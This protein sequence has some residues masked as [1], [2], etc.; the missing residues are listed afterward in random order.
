MKYIFIG[1]I[2]TLSWLFLPELTPVH[3]AEVRVVEIHPSFSGDRFSTIHPIT[4]GGNI[5]NYRGKKAVF[6]SSPTSI[7]PIKGKGFMLIRT[8]HSYILFEGADGNPTSTLTSGGPYDRNGCEPFNV[9]WPEQDFIK[10]NGVH[11]YG[12]TWGLHIEYYNPCTLTEAIPALYLHIYDE[13]DWYALPQPPGTNLTL[14]H[15]EG[16]LDNAPPLGNWA[17]NIARVVE[18][19]IAYHGGALVFTGTPDGTKPF[20]TKHGIYGL[21]LIDTNGGYLFNKELPLNPA[22]IKDPKG[23]LII[24]LEDKTPR[25][26]KVQVIYDIR[27]SGYLGKTITYPL[28]ILEKDIPGVLSTDTVAPFLDLPWKYWDETSDEL[29]KPEELEN[30]KNKFQTVAAKI[31]SYFDHKYPLCYSPFKHLDDAQCNSTSKT[32]LTYRNIL[33][34]YY[35]GH[36][37]YDWNT[38]VFKARERILAK[39]NGTATYYPPS[40]NAAKGHHLVV[41]YQNGQ[42]EEYTLLVNPSDEP[43]TVT[44]TNVPIV[45]GQLL[46]RQSEPILAAADGI[47]TTGY[48]NGWGRYIKI[49][50]GNGFQTIY[51]HLQNDSFVTGQVKAGERIGVAG[52]TGNVRSSN[53]ETQGVHLHFGVL[54]DKNNNGFALPDDYVDPFGWQPDDKNAKDP[55]E[56]LVLTK[57]ADGSALRTGSK[58]YYLWKFSNALPETPPAKTPPPLAAGNF[59]VVFTKPSG[60]FS[61]SPLSI[62]AVLSPILGFIE[63]IGNLIPVS[64]LLKLEAKNESGASVSQFQNDV[65]I[66]Y[67]LDTSHL[68]QNNS[69]KLYTSKD[70]TTWNLEPTTVTYNNNMLSACVKHFTYFVFMGEPQDGSPPTTQAYLK[71]NSGV[72]NVYRSDVELSLTAEDGNGGS[73]VAAT[74][75]S[76]NGASRHIYT[77]PLVFTQEGTHEVLFYSEDEAHNIEIPKKVSF[78]IDK[79]PPE[80]V[81]TFNK[82]VDALEILPKTD[83]IA[84]P[85]SE[86]TPGYVRITSTLSSIKNRKHWVEHTLTDAAG[87][88][89]TLLTKDKNELRKDSITIDEL[90]YNSTP[91]ALFTKIWLSVNG[92]LKKNSTEEARFQQV[93]RLH[94]GTG[95]KEKV[96]LLWRSKT[97][98]TTIKELAGT[99]E[100]KISTKSG[101]L[102][103]QLSFDNGTVKY[104]W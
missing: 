5:P 32:T 43:K 54:H 22:V 92:S 84:T 1:L 56:E 33:A 31:G 93:Y 12:E 81:I 53:P 26:L 46:A 25:S 60:E 76:V 24:E 78:T 85:G 98:S 91:S 96:S 8:A 61:E 30:R 68:Y 52:H 104:A 102:L 55:W 36:D 35:S 69:Y 10:T 64:P 62:K 71:G 6:S 2:F 70:G 16:N 65:C 59:Q 74:Y 94:T 29:N 34:N 3:A 13:E 14:I 28:Y 80:F 79:T 37:G 63:K 17:P 27:N 86:L 90:Y 20:F 4:T 19:E 48:D 75:V 97:G 50:H 41:T 7:E 66:S 82:L 99:Q 15:S 39:D 101:Q 44:D 87:N 89:T 45:K 18:K 21:N 72:S 49:D 23:P 42:T 88:T 83:T 9:S 38:S 95:F 77:N 40:A 73:G 100:A 103:L 67:K 11:I 51:A 47:A 58:S 57:N